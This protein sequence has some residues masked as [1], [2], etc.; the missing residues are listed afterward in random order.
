LRCA[1]VFA[2][3]RGVKH[4]GIVGGEHDEDA[5]AKSYGKGCC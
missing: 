5:R 1:F 3:E 4:C 2:E